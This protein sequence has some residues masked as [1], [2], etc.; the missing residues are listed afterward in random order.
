MAVPANSLTELLA[1]PRRVPR[2]GVNGEY[3]STC[4]ARPQHRCTSCLYLHCDCSCS[5]LRSCLRQTVTVRAGAPEASLDAD[6][7]PAIAAAIVARGEIVAAGAVGTRRAS[8]TNPVSVEDRFH[9]RSGTKAM[10]SLL[11]ER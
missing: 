1:S 11:A 6:D 5:S 3:Q 8:I 2:S 7:L 10:T 9:I 4:N